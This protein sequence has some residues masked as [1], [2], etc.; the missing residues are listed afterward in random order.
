VL[1]HGDKPQLLATDEHLSAG[2][3]EDLSKLIELINSEKKK[4]STTIAL[5]TKDHYDASELINFLRER[6]DELNINIVSHAEEDY[7]T[8]L[9]VLPVT[10]AKGL[11]FDTVILGDVSNQNYTQEELDIRLLYV[12]ITRALHRLYVLYPENKLSNLFS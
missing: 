3:A 1:R 8:G 6:S 9:L 7:Q 12:A 11:E 10:K 5:I 4:G 2:K